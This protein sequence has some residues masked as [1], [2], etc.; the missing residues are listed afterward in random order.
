MQAHICICVLGREVDSQK[1]WD[2]NCVQIVHQPPSSEGD[3]NCANTVI[4]PRN[5]KI[6]DNT[7]HT[8]NYYK[9]AMKLEENVTA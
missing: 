6:S 4:Y 1:N 5:F 8:V 7:E 9:Y 3:K 2:L